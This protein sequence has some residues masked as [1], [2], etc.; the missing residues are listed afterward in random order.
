MDTELVLRGKAM[1]Q[2]ICFV[3]DN[4]MQSHVIWGCYKDE[5]GNEHEGYGIQ[6]E[7]R[8]G[9][10]RKIPD[11]ST[12]AVAVGA[13]VE[14]MNRLRVSRYHIDDVIQDFLES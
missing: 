6:V 5:D 13:L 8:F 12:D 10:I 2:S 9:V 14:K 11:I 3:I 7:N 1:E 4:R